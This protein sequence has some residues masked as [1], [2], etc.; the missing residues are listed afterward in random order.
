MIRR[1]LLLEDQKLTREALRRLLSKRFPAT[2][3]ECAGYEDTAQEILSRCQ[4]DGTV[5]DAAILDVMVPPR[6]GLNPAVS[7]VCIRVRQQFPEVL[8]GHIT[9]YADDKQVAE[10]RSLLEMDPRYF[11]VEKTENNDSG[12]AWDDELVQK[13]AR[14]ELVRQGGFLGEDRTRTVARRREAGHRHQS[15]TF[16]R[17]ALVRDI[18]KYWKLLSP[19]FKSTIKRYFNVDE[20]HE[21][22][23]VR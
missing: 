19:E 2:I 3:V 23:I 10:L 6:K 4:T 12:L 17:A 7:S 13:L 9:A 8:I 22:V 18:S 1:I 16:R 11:F 5:I 14:A 21:P 20:D 15:G